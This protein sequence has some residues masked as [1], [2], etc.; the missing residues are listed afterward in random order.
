MFSN[1]VDILSQPFSG[2]AT[3]HIAPGVAWHGR[4]MVIAWLFIMPLIVLIARFYKVTPGQ[5]W[6]NRLDNPFWFIWHRRGGYALSA[7]VVI[8]MFAVIFSNGGY[9][10]LAS[11][12]AFLG[13]MVLSLTVIQVVGAIMR[14]THGGP[15]DPFTRRRKPESEWPGDH[16]SMTRKRIVFEYTHK[17]LGYLLIPLVIL[18]LFSGLYDADAP[19]WM[20]LTS[21]ILILI[22]VAAFVRLQLLGRCIDT[23]QAIW[24]T[25]P[26]LPGNKR[27]SP[28]GVGV[29]RYPNNFSRGS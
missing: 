17:I 5:D 29:R 11:P 27:N 9:F 18:A 8:A 10:R 12:H 19:R 24:G 13:I 6:P 2:A 21:A 22:S 7:V 23:Y 20:W 15:I 3:H 16:F 28:I 1:L 4:L 25:D 26:A 14:G